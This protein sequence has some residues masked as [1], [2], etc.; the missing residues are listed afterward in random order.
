[1][2]YKSLVSF[3]TEAARIPLVLEAGI[4]LAR[5]E[6]AH[7]DV[8]CLGIDHTQPGFFYAGAPAMIYQ[9]TLDQARA[10]SE[11]LEAEVRK[12]LKAEDIRWGVEAG[13]VQLGTMAHLV[14]LRAR[15][16]DLVLQPKP[17]GET[18]DSAA[19]AVL[20]AALFEGRAPILVLPET[21]LGKTLG[22][23]IVVAWNESEEALSAVRR[24]LPMLIAAEAV[25]IV[26]V[27]P[28][29]QGPER[30]DPGGLLTQMLVRHGVRAEVS[31]IANTMPRISDLLCRHV[32]DQ[33][34]DMLVMGAYGHSRLRQAILGGATRNMLQMADV[35]VFMAR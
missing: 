5:R 23:R 13:V 6:D 21:G 7:L 34:A 16:A 2:A 15:F 3:V 31:V 9:E 24:A 4:R 26:I 18:T 28:P 29:A 1:M 17:Y 11:A 8:V 19:E 35:P 25:N 22:Q 10:E 12:R 33:D 20:E 30:S 27:D 32:R 14:S